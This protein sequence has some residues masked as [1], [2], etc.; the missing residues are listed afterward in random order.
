MGEDFKLKTTFLS[1]QD[2]PGTL[3]RLKKQNVLSRL[4]EYKR[5]VYGVLGCGKNWPYFIEL[6]GCTAD[7]KESTIGLG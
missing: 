5:P 7:V 3:D 1:Q 2:F 4:K 6:R